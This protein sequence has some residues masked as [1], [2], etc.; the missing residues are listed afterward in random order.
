MLYQSRKARSYAIFMISDMVQR[1]WL[2]RW[3]YGGWIES[4][5]LGRICVGC[6][7]DD[8]LYGSSGNI[9]IGMVANVTSASAMARNRRLAFSLYRTN[10][11]LGHW[12]IHFRNETHAARR[13]I[14]YTVDETPSVVKPHYYRGS[15]V[16]F[17]CMKWTAPH[18]LVAGYAK[19]CE[20][21]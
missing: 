3:C 2:D 18:N 6:N 8:G 10:G 1:D 16:P 11:K 20:R 12:H 17:S 4:L 21:F 19:F 5:G 15:R 14:T 7:C 13:E 9:V